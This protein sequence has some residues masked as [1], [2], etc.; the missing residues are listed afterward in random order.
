M[1]IEIRVAPRIDASQTQCLMKLVWSA[2]AKPVE[3]DA[4]NNRACSVLSS[5]FDLVIVVGLQ[6]DRTLPLSVADDERR[7]LISA[8]HLQGSDYC[9]FADVV[10]SRQHRQPFRG[11][12]DSPSVGH[13]V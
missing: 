1:D 5:P 3:N 2:S 13:E 11:L 12:N 9:A 8:E 4:V 10:W 7:V 6:F